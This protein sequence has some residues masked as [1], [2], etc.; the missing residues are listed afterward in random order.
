MQYTM[1]SHSA[2]WPLYQKAIPTPYTTPKIYTSTITIL[3]RNIFPLY[4]NNNIY[5]NILIFDNH[6]QNGKPVRTSPKYYITLLYI[7][8]L[9]YTFLYKL[10]FLHKLGTPYIHPIFSRSSP[11]AT[12]DPSNAAYKPI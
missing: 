12:R 10:S 2:H 6:S 8:V 3:Y 9:R 1:Q 11:R 4:Q 7:V 5:I